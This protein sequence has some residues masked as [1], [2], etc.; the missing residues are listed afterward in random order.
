MENLSMSGVLKRDGDTQL[1][2]QMKLQ[3]GKFEVLA[4]LERG[5]ST[6]P[7][8]DWARLQ[9]RLAE[10]GVRMAPLISSSNRVSWYAA[11]SFP[12][13]DRKLDEPALG[14]LPAAITKAQSHKSGALRLSAALATTG[15]H[16][17][18]YAS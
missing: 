14:S 2:L 7:D 5:K 3:R 16:N 11:G 1:S 15:G 8:A 4:V 18:I 10:H 17:Q 13:S 9:F 6:T 12:A